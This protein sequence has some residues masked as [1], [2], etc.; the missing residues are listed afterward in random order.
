MHKKSLSAMSMSFSSGAKK[1]KEKE[2]ENGN[3]RSQSR[4]RGSMDLGDKLRDLVSPNRS[5][6]SSPV[7]DAAGKKPKKAKSAIDIAL[8]RRRSPEKKAAQAR[9]KENRV[10]PPGEEGAAGGGARGY[11]RRSRGYSE[12]VPSSSAAAAA[13]V[14][15]GMF[16]G[17]QPG[18]DPIW[19][20]SNRASVSSTLDNPVDLT[21]SPGHVASS[22]GSAESSRRARK[23]QEKEEKEE[24]E[25][26]KYAP[27]E[28]DRRQQ[29]QQ[30][31][32]AESS[33]RSRGRS[34]KPRPKSMFASAKP[35]EEEGLMGP[36]PR[37]S[38][39]IRRSQDVSRKPLPDPPREDRSPEKKSSGSFGRSGAAL[40]LDA[41]NEAFEKLLVSWE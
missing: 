8:L 19:N 22:P 36:P 29:Y 18:Q 2:K 23:K 21:S 39:D 37:K 25:R 11:F 33:E 28:L 30:T 16:E 9:D 6:P 7:G 24:L 15:K 27:A 32:S 4:P 12:V 41:I 35:K 26:R 40:D 34:T 14:G 38:V 20:R 10:P 31:G 13:A 5:R 3:K 17:V 1:D